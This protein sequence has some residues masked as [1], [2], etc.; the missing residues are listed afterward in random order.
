MAQV[1]LVIDMQAGLWDETADADR[2][3][4]TVQTLVARARAAGVPIVWV[5]DDHVQPPD[6]HPALHSGDDPLIVKHH[7][8]AFSETSL[9]VTLDRLAATEIVICGFHTDFC[10]D[11]TTRRA[12]QEGFAVTLV[13]DAHSTFDREGL[14]AAT[15]VA[16]HNAVL[17]NLAARGQVTARPAAMVSF[18]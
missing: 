2:V 8:D 10:I 6:L 5:A 9:G 3:L 12:A 4:A 14:P 7:C 18:A 15:V 17:G 16:H 1:L 11:T 13:T